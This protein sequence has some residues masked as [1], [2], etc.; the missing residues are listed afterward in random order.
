MPNQYS[1]SAI[2]KKL[3]IANGYGFYEG[4]PCIRCGRTKKD[5]KASCCVHCRKERGL[6]KLN[7]PE[8]MAKY[9]TPEKRR[10]KMNNW[11][12]NNPEKYKAQ[13][14]RAQE[15]GVLTAKASRRR[16][17]VRNQMP[18]TADLTLI[19]EYYAEA[20]R[21][22]RDTGIPHEVDHIIPIS[23]GGLHHQDNLRVITMTENRSKGNRV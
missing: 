1:Q 10:A 4:E 23:K 20:Q 8:L 2:N 14:D 22:T 13:A 21:M 12:K 7:N 6:A 11:R 19:L 9:R 5:I 17:R 18:D 16:A 3:A 15:R